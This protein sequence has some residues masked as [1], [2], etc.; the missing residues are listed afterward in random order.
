[1]T[2]AICSAGVFTFAIPSSHL[3][4]SQR[5]LLRSTDSVPLSIEAVSCAVGRLVGSR[6]TSGIDTNSA[7]LRR[8]VPALGPD[9][10]A[11]APVP[12]R[13]A[14]IRPTATIVASELQKRVK[15]EGV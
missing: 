2:T 15:P 9:V 8:T 5:E 4:F 6:I 10:T 1:M 7:I 14:A 11:T 3:N 13:I 12:I